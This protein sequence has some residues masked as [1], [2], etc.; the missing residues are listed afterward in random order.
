MKK[1]FF[2]TLLLAAMSTT[3]QEATDSI[4]NWFSNPPTSSKKFYGTG[5]GRAAYL[6]VAEKKA[7]LNANLQLA[8]QVDKPKVKEIKNKTKTVTGQDNE[9]T[10]QRTIVEAKLKGVKVINK[11]VT[12][13][14]DMY[15]VYIL[16]EMKR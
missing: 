11:Y 15:I 4:P 10:I 6:D 7:M 16:V 5:E 9:T 14:G 12:Q 1:I 8:E 2:I 3:A 13:K